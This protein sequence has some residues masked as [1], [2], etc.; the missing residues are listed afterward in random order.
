MSTSCTL[1]ER[2]FAREYIRTFMVT[3]AAKA[4]GISKTTAYK[5]LAK[6]CVQ[7]FIAEEMSRRATR[8]QLDMDRI[9]KELAIIAQSDVTDY[10]D[11]S[12]GRL[13][14]FKD[15]STLPPEQTRCIQ[16]IKE[17][18]DQMG[19]ITFEIKL[20]D[21]LKAIRIVADSLTNMI[22]Q[23]REYIDTHKQAQVLNINDSKGGL[24]APKVKLL[25]VPGKIPTLAEWESQMAEIHKDRQNEGVMD[26]EYTTIAA[27]KA[28]KNKGL[29]KEDNEDDEFFTE[30]SD[31][32]S[33]LFDEDNTDGFD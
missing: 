3:E 32:G 13:L 21:K 8:T 23:M 1:T 2:T 33:G 10:F 19:N 27:T 29:K 9:I 24:D 18:M 22:I 30:D 26:A 17:H 25:G 11:N 6:E 7:D 28:G 14:T 12:G 5:Y 31:E 15:L 20:Y 4:T 16:S